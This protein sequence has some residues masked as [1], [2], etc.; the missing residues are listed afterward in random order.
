MSPCARKVG[1]FTLVPVLLGLGMPGAGVMFGD[2]VIMAPDGGRLDA[3]D[4]DGNVVGPCPLRHTDVHVEIAGFLTRVTVRQTYHNPYPNTIEAVYTFPLSHRGAVDRMIMTIGDRTVVGEVHERSRARAI[5]EAARESGYVASLLE[6][7]RPNIFTQSVANIEP[8]A[9][10]IV[11]IGYVELLDA[12]EGTYRFTFPMVVGPRYIPGSMQTPAAALPAP[13][14]PRHGLLL[15]CPAKL[16][17]GRQGDVSRLGTLQTG[18]LDALLRAATPI[19]A[20]DS[21]TA[22]LWYQFE[23]AY[24]DGSKEIGSLHTDG[25]GQI[26]GRW[27]YSDPKAT[28]D[29]GTGFAPDTDQVPDASRIT[30]EPVRPGKRAGH[31]ISMRVTLDTGGPGIA[32][33]KS[34]LHEILETQKVARDDGLPRRVTVELKKEIEIPNRD[35]VLTWRPT[36]DA[37]QEATF[38]HT[39][40]HGRFFTLI[41]QP[42]ARVAEAQA[43][44]R[45]LIFVLDTSGSMSGFP[46][47]K[48]KEV[49]RKLIDTMGPQDTFN[50]ITF[51]GDTSILWPQ[52]LPGTPENI[53]AAQ[54]FLATRR[55]GGGTE[56]MKAID[57]ALVQTVR[58]R[59][60]R[61]VR[62]CCFMTDGYVGNDMAIIDAVRKNAGTTRVFSFGI[63]N[64]VNRY[65]LDG[66][67]RAGR[68]EAEYVLLHGDGD[69]AAKRFARRIQ[70]PVLTDVSL[71]FS[72]GLKVSDLMPHQAPDL[73]DARPL[74]IHGRYAAPGRGTV[75]IRGVTGAGPF[76][77]TVTLDLPAEQ[78]GHDV[79]ATLWA[80]EKVEY[81]MNQDLAAAQNGQFPDELRQE[82]IR[83][84]EEYRIMTQF[85]RFVAVEKTRV[86]IGG[87]P[88][89]VAVPVEMPQGVSY[90]GVF[91]PTGTLSEELVKG[92][93]ITETRAVEE[94]AAKD[95]V[96]R[97]RGLAENV[98]AAAAP[99]GLP[100]QSSALLYSAAESADAGIWGGV[101]RSSARYGGAF[102]DVAS[103]RGSVRAAGIGPSS[104]GQG[105]LHHSRALRS[106][107]PPPPA[108]DAG[109][110]TKPADPKAVEAQRLAAA[111]Q[112]A[113][114]DITPHRMALGIARLVA[115]HRV[116]EARK[117]AAE[118]VARYPDYKIGAQMRDVLADRKLK[119]DRRDARIQALAFDARKAIEEAIRLGQ[120]RARVDDRLFRFLTDPVGKAPPSGL[121]IKG[122]GVRVSVLVRTLD[123]ATRNALAKAGLKI[124]AAVPASSFVVGVLP[125]DRLAT[126]ALREEV[127]KIDAVLTE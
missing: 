97:T 83:L 38:T 110:E 24:P 90:E 3:V 37:I 34:E 89:L 94:L 108:V 51:S 71:A 75:T 96:R 26:N 81:L 116:D 82:V 8:G 45:E 100:A 35:F 43:V 76:E 54:Q 12:R 33:L 60:V 63:G 77:R 50:L 20:P 125:K 25:T 64:S 22:P 15:L 9:E 17:V 95:L 67:A 68:G 102:F 91:G 80:R 46:I 85:T 79:I 121:Q 114:G 55:G 30:P 57:A 58:N 127:R 72:D 78:P 13:F 7:E 21:P 49:M 69:A 98:P 122:D 14:K 86:T 119:P 32:E 31:D 126:V 56:M 47:E 106:A 111:L 36:A 115:D 104:A 73:W 1:I 19:N 28:K 61:P 18:K 93:A 123:D 103:R 62:I 52:P 59:P 42:P 74:V 11:E 4:T 5:Y 107:P 23:A 92:M 65:L 117:L 39:G 88:Q 112:G 2:D 44:P 10:V 113:H 6:Q 99:L 105:Q 66:M 27:F 48:A 118:L 124:E 120:I 101:G 16:S 29:M 41:L 109:P 53:A 84:G 70:T 87:K 40:P